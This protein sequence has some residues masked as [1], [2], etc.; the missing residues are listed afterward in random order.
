MNKPDFLIIPTSVAF[1]KELQPL[2][3]MVYGIIYWMTKL[4]LEKCIAGNRTLAD[5]CDC[6]LK[7]IQKSI[8]RLEDKKYIKRE[9]ENDREI[10]PLVI[11]GDRQMAVTPPPNGG[12]DLKKRIKKEETN[13]KDKELKKQKEEILNLWNSLGIVIHKNWP[14]SADPRFTYLLEHIGFDEIKKTIELYA[15]VLKDSDCFFSYKWSLSAFIQRKN[16]CE[17]WAGKNIGD[18]KTERSKQGERKAIS[19]DFNTRQTI[20]SDGSREKMKI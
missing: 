7:S 17:E 3:K 1:D 18:Y 6:N 8:K 10:V 9:S 16:G 15:A 5:L 12:D 19:Y 4:K 20:F 14:D 11:F 2:D 13:L